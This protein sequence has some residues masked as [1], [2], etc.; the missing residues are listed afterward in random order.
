VKC[1]IASSPCDAR[2]LETISIVLARVDPPAPQ[3][4]DTNAGSSSR[5]CSR[6]EN[7]FCSPSAVLGGK[8]SNENTGSRPPS[9]ISS[10]RIA[11]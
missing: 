7:R 11:D 6:A 2:I 5:S 3:V 4:T 9:M 8:N 1:A 10:M